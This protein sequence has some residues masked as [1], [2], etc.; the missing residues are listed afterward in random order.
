MDKT[1]RIFPH[2][3]AVFHSM[4]ASHSS[5]DFPP[6]RAVVAT[7]CLELSLDYDGM[8]HGA[9]DLLLVEEVVATGGKNELCASL[10]E[11]KGPGDRLSGKQQAVREKSDR[12]VSGS[13]FRA[14]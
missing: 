5:H 6:F 12:F 8:S 11:V 7:I 2:H 13:N 4:S 1:L 14:F 10:V 9:P 3:F